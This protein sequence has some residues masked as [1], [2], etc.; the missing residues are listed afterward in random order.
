MVVHI[1]NDTSQS[2]P[3]LSSCYKRILIAAVITRTQVSIQHILR[4]VKQ[5]HSNTQSRSGLYLTRCSFN[6][7]QNR[8][9]YATDLN[10]NKIKRYYSPTQ[11]QIISLPERCDNGLLGRQVASEPDYNRPR[12]VFWIFF[13]YVSF[14]FIINHNK[15]G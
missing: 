6:A 7:L 5:Q 12:F 1:P 13:T 15:Y 14:R 2:I 3:C 9:F 4:S 10:G 11:I 8:L